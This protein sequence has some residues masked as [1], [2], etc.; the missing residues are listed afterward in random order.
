MSTSRPRQPTIGRTKPLVLHVVEAYGGG[1]AAVLTDYVASLPDV[2]HV[3]LAY[4]RPGSQI[5]NG[6]HGRAELIDLPP[7]KLAQLWPCAA[8]SSGCDPTSSTP[9]RRTPAATCAPRAASRRRAHRVLAALLLLP[10]A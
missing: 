4:R 8:P 3:V 2:E 9:I 6:L 7:G 5:G 1:V 10:A